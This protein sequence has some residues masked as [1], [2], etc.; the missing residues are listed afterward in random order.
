VSACV[1]AVQHIRRL[2]GGS[3]SQLLRACDEQYYVTKFQN[4]PQHIRVL[5][6][7]MF[8]TRVGELLG[9]PVP[10]VTAI[11]VCDWLIE[12]TPDL[13]VDVAGVR[14]RFHAGIHLGSAYAIDPAEG[15]LFD[16]LPEGLLHKV[17]NIEDF[18][19]VL[20][21]DKWTGNA[22]GRQ[23]VFCSPSSR[24]CYRAIF[25]DQGYCF[26]AGEWTFPDSPL[27][28]V[29]TRNTVYENV[30]DWT[31]FEPALTRAEEM[32]IDQIWTIAREIPEEWYEHDSDGLN[33]LVEQLH[34]RRSQIRTLITSFRESSRNPFSNWTSV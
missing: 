23:V 9:L 33:R 13:R 1:S 17:S 25:I 21:L 30:R 3:Q 4:N 22:D 15:E 14:T 28:G 16:Y 11:K 7:E 32:S 6:N 34:S 18:A 31:A 12:N 2:R 29:Y 24:F 5:A 26:N 20:V 8:A 10:R 19:R 27:R